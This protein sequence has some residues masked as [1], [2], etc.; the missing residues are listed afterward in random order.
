[1]NKKSRLMRRADRIWFEK[2]LKEKCEVCGKP[3]IQV[4]HFFP[5]G[6]YGHLRY[7]TSN[8]VSLCR[9]CHFLIHHA[10]PKIRDKIIEV[11]GKK[12][13]DE[14]KEK[15]KEIHISHKTIKY[16]EEI[17]SKLSL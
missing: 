6:L 5:K 9:G 12:W 15:S 4:H 3:A 14:L 7:N 8:G 16:Y 2:L 17:I 13:Y 11:R 1:M 10:D